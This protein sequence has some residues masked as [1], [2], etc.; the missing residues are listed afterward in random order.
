MLL[1]SEVGY[2]QDKRWPGV[3]GGPVVE[4]R[5]KS[6]L[7]DMDRIEPATSRLHNTHTYLGARHATCK[8][9]QKVPH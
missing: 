5:P 1:L 7:Y 2:V 9:V 8:G 4:A 6:K 3:V